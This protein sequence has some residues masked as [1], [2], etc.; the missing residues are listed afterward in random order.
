MDKEGGGFVLKHLVN[1]LE[2]STTEARSDKSR[3][4]LLIMMIMRMIMVIMMMTMMMR[5]MTM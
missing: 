5:T 1:K 2:A 4:T 3:L